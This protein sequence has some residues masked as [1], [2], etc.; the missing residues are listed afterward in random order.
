MSE[1]RDRYTDTYTDAVIPEGHHKKYG[2]LKNIKKLVMCK[3]MHSLSNGHDY[4]AMCM[5]SPLVPKFTS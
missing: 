4:L 5:P 2:G 3:L 1:T